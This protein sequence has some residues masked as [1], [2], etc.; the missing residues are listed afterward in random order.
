MSRLL[1]NTY[2]YKTP[3]VC[4]MLGVSRMTLWNWEKEGKFIPPKNTHGDRIFTITQ[5]KQI[6]NAFS[7]GGKGYWKF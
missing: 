3:D 1:E 4:K 2:K 5:L 6:K 7:P